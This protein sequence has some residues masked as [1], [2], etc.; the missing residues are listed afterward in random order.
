[1][2]FVLKDSCHPA[3]SISIA[4]ILTSNTDTFPMAAQQRY[5]FRKANFTIYSKDL[6]KI[7]WS[8]RNSFDDIIVAL[9]KFYNVRYRILYFSF[10]KI[11]AI[12]NNYPLWF[13]IEIKRSL[14][15]KYYYWAK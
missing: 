8:S 6:L 1:M 11:V 10:P 14:N 5:N 9:A 3:L 15:V 7:K 13:I 4:R 12:L 2:N